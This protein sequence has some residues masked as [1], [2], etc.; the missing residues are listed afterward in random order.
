MTSTSKKIKILVVNEFSQLATGF[1]TYM[2][3]VM[4]ELHKND[5]YEVAELAGHCNSQDPRLAYIPWKVYPNAPNPNNQEEIQAFQSNPVNQ[6]GK[7]K[8]DETCLD[9][10]PDVVLTIRDP[11]FD[12]WIEKSPYRKYFK[13]IHMPTCD[14]EPQKQEWMEFYESCDLLLTYSYWSKHILETQS[15]GKLKIFDVASPAVEHEI[16]RP[17]DKES[18]RKTVGF[19][20][21]VN[22]I[23][24]VMRNQPRKLYPEILKAFNR[25][26]DICKENG[27]D[28]IAAKTFLYWHTSSPDVG[29]DLPYEMRQHKMSHKVLFTYICRNCASVYPAFYKGDT[30]FC[31]NCR[32]PTAQMPN[33]THGVDRNSLAAIYNLAD[34]LLQYSV[35]EGWGMSIPEAKACAIPVMGS[36]YSAMTEQVHSPGGIAIPVGRMFQE[37]LNQT[38][39]LRSLPDIEATAQELFKFFCTTKEQQ[40]EIGRQGREL[41]EQEYTWP[42]I[43]QIWEQAIDSLVYPDH[44]DTWL[45]E[46]KLYSLP[47]NI[48]QNLGNIQFIE[49]CYHNILRE[50]FRFN[51]PM[52]RKMISSLEDGYETIHSPDGQLKR[53][54]I[55]K[56]SILNWCAQ[57]VQQKNHFEQYRYNLLV[58]GINLNSRVGPMEL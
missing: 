46:P 3:N 15:G 40:R 6:F 50:Q 14:G 39:Q 33:T 25:F 13:F 1:A 51:E 10:K 9:F 20:D 21:D 29:W 53:L 22:I 19:A 28:D 54:P 55:D 16:F 23:L 47:Q 37:P 31:K 42:K 8:F 2:Q 48:P 45:S 11:W 49:Y 18:L 35:C 24:S 58:K 32:K 43:T 52:A 4:Q 7:W 56:N 27:R 57:Q 30:A 17:L 26:L 12:M 38:N 34:L 36:E 44:K 41:I 5:K